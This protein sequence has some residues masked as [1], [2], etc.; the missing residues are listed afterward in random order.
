MWVCRKSR[1]SIKS[2]EARGELMMY[3]SCVNV[4]LFMVSVTVV[5]C[6]M[7][8]GVLLKVCAVMF[9]GLSGWEGGRVERDITEIDAPVSIRAVLCRFL[10]VESAGKWMVTSVR[11]WSLVCMVV[12]FRWGG[13][14][15]DVEFLR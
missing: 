6:V 14:E 4:W 12:C 15:G 11:A 3:S 7:G 10:R 8:T 9:I 2:H 1:P 13:S 5:V